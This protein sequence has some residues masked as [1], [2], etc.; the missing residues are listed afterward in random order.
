ML[1]IILCSTIL[2]SWALTVTCDFK[3]VIASLYSTFDYPTKQCTYS[4]VWVTWLAPY[5]TAAVLALSAYNHAP[6]HVTSYKATC[7]VPWHV[8]VAVTCH[9]HFWQSDWD[10]LNFIHMCCCSNTG[11]EWILKKESAQKVIL[12]RR[13]GMDTEKRVNTESY[14][15]EFSCHCWDLNPWPFDYKS[16]ALTTELFL[17][18]TLDLGYISV[19]VAVKR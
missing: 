2:Q 17:L 6:C 11:V 13:S 14:S 7:R 9:L 15:G 10:L 18:P 19:T 8:C 1:L 16:G 12:E 4:T 3:W 5:E